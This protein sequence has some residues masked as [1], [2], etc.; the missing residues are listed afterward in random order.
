MATRTRKKAT[1][2]AR[3]GAAVSTTQDQ[4][5]DTVHQVWLAGLGALS[6]AQRGAP[7]VFNDLV[8]EGARVHAS[9]SRSADKAVRSVVTRAQAAIQQRI[10]GAR[11]KASDTLENLE[12]VFQTRVQRALHQMGVP[13]S[14]DIDRLSAR[15]EAL[16]A[17]IEKLARRR[18]TARPGDGKRTAAA[19][20]TAAH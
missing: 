5:L 9:A 7:K 2:V 15:V 16:N 20:T 13:G 12:K 8:K 10:G 3:I 14:R 18:V 17:S 11:E 1:R 4:L 19:S 6:K